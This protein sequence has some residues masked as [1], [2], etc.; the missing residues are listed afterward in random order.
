MWGFYFE[1][2]GGFVNFV[3]NC[4]GMKSKVILSRY[5]LAVTVI[6]MVAVFIGCVAT[7][8]E[9]LPFFILLGVYVLLLIFA[10]FYGAF[11]IQADSEYI[12]MGSLLRKRK[13]LMR[14]VESVELFQPTMGAIRIFGSGGFFG[15]WGIFSEGDIGRYSAFYGKASDCFLVRMKNGD[16]YVLGC[17]NPAEMVAW[18]DKERVR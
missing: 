18:I 4:I 11:Y 16:K 3:E 15:Y 5:S 17:K 8:R 10:L 14:N 1:F 12:I 2:W 7:V 13:I 6:T 9:K